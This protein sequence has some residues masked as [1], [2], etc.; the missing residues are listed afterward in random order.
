[1][2]V[3]SVDGDDMDT[4]EI[5]KALKASQEEAWRRL[6]YADENV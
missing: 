6:D 3:K 5:T 4:A 2:T 1:M